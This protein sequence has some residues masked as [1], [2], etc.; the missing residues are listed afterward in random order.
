MNNFEYYNPVNIVFGK[1]QIKKLK[2]LIPRG[3]KIL[4]TYGGGSIKRNGVYDQV[5]E[6]LSDHDFIE[7]GGIEANPQYETLMSACELAKKEQISFLLAVG[8]GSVI[9]GTKFIAVAMHHSDDPWKI[10]S[11]RQSIQGATP[12][13]SVLTLP[14]TGSEMNTGS[15][16]SRGKE[17]LGC[18]GDPRMYPK[19]S[20]LDPEVTYSLPERQLGNGIVDSYVHVLEQYLTKDVNSPLQD[21]MAESILKTLIEEGPK[22][23]HVKDDYASRA[24]FMWCAT[25]ALNGLIGSGVIHDW[26]THMIGHEI[27]AFHGVDH[28]RTLALVMPS[29]LR[30]QKEKKQNKLLQYADRV[31]NLSNGTPDERIEQAIILTEDFFNSLGVPTKLRAYNIKEEDINT[32]VESVRSHIPVNL[33]ENGDIDGEKIKTILMQA[34]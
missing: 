27:T 9:D 21:R 5:I 16:V 1:G 26:A 12:L 28:G 6:A 19:F 24:N 17:K 11:Q 32:I 14:A 29:L 15:V 2:D 25:M 31:W 22:V 7:F 20:I 34:L 30:V 8:G 23:I 13:G 3:E 10:L 4:I 33:G 18:F